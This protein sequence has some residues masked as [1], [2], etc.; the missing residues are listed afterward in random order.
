[1]NL[2]ELCNG[3]LSSLEIFD[4]A[5]APLG[6]Y[7][8]DE[9][10]ASAKPKARYLEWSSAIQAYLRGIGAA[11]PHNSSLSRNCLQSYAT[12]PELGKVGFTLVKFSKIKVRKYGSA[13]HVDKH[14]DREGR[15]NETDLSGIV[16]SLWK[17]NT[18]WS[19]Y[20]EHAH[21][22]V[23]IGFDKAQR[24]LERELTELQATLRWHEKNVEYTTRAFEDKAGRGF[25]IRLAAW[26][27]TR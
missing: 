17:H 14:E 2:T 8:S 13:Y 19:N 22:V 23:F 24:P 18:D 7:A 27:R 20:N 12:V 26:A 9:L 10:V 21:I 6:L 4:E 5:T 1:M 25:G 15:W 3:V 16:S 11:C